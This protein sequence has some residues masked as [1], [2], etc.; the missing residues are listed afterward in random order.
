MLVDSQRCRRCRY[1]RL[2][3]LQKM[4][5]DD[6]DVYRCAECGYIFSPPQ[7][8]EQGAGPGSHSISPGAAGRS[9]DKLQGPSSPAHQD[10]RTSL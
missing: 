10:R 3:K 5:D 9:R 1:R 4:R 2:I 7:E 6:H 8:K